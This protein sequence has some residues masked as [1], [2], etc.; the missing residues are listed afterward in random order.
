MLHYYTNKLITTTLP[1]KYYRFTLLR[2]CTITLC[3]DTLVLYYTITLLQAREISVL[4][5]QKKIAEGDS[6]MKQ[7][8][9]LYEAVRSDR[10]IYSKKLIE[11]QV[12]SCVEIFR[13]MG[14]VL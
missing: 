4:Q 12:S 6:R 9:N 8:Q 7:Q 13:C 2:F 10:N 14:W 1:H 3:T 11:D 5:L